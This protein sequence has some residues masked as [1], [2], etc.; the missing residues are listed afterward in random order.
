MQPI[1]IKVKNV[2]VYAYIDPVSTVVMEMFSGA[3]GTYSVGTL[4]TSIFYNLDIDNE[5]KKINPLTVHSKY[6]AVCETEDGHIFT[7]PWMYCLNNSNKPTFGRTITAGGSNDAAA[8]VGVVAADPSGFIKLGPLTDITVSQLFPPPAIGQRTLITNGSG[9]IIATRIGTPHE[10][11][12]QV[13]KGDRFGVITSGMKN[14]IIS[15]KT[16]DGNTF[17]Q[18]GYTAISGGQP[19]IFLKKFP[20]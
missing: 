11:G 9:N 1:P 12:V 19:A 13:D 17:A 5:G 10:M 3:S 16:K 8:D 18:T 15:G 2:S 7:T 14:I 20:Y 6:Y 4:M